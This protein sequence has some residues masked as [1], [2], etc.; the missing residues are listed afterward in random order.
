MAAQRAAST[1]LVFCAEGGNSAAFT[2][3][4]GLPPPSD[5]APTSGAGTDCRRGGTPQE[6]NGGISKPTVDVW[7][8]SA[9]K[10]QIAKA[11]RVT[12]H[13]ALKQ[14]ATANPLFGIGSKS[15]ALVF[16]L[17]KYPSKQKALQIPLPHPVIVG[18]STE[19]GLFLK[20]AKGKK[21]LSVH[22]GR[23]DMEEDAL[24]KNAVAVTNAVRMRLDN[25]LVHEITV[26]MERLALP[27]WN[28]KTSARGRRRASA[29]ACLNVDSKDSKGDC[30]PPPVRPPLKRTRIT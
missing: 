10:K 18:H 26:E 23:C 8:E 27:V 15:L 22:F 11:I 14:N 13:V 7:S 5:L 12:K 30:M 4:A 9:T 17:K 28:H 24:L 16:N 1:Q 2:N 25:R 6:L 19:V 29:K 20:T 21:V 3:A